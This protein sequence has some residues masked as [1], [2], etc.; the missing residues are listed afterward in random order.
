[1]KNIRRV[2]ITGLGV[3]SL[4]ESAMIPFGETDHRRLR[5]GLYAGCD[6]S[7]AR[8]QPPNPLTSA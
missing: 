3:A 2:V 8:A 6:R 5:R 1:M 4:G 7:P